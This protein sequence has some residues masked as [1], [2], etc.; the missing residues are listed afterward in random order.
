MLEGSVLT[1]NNVIYLEVA[2][3]LLGIIK[4]SKLKSRHEKYSSESWELSNLLRYLTQEVDELTEALYLGEPTHI[5]EEV[6]D[7][8]NMCDL[9]AMAVID[10]LPAASPLAR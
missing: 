9:L 2:H 8:S 10:S 5:L 6:A 3:H 7:V 1:G 4:Q